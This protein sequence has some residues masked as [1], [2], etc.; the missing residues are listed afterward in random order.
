MS[1]A[2]TKCENTIA[3]RSLFQSLV[4]PARSS[5]LMA[6]GRRHIV[7]HRQVRFGQ[8]EFARFHR[9]FPRVRRED[10]L[11]RCLPINSPIFSPFR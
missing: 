9:L 11:H 1:L 2:G 5:A 8:N 4:M 3:M 6:I 7:G 10:L